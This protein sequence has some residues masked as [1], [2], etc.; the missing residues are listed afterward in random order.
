MPAI[1]LVA[2]DL[3]GTLLRKGGTLSEYSQGVL[4]RTQAGGVQLVLVTGRPVRLVR[5][6]ARDVAP[7][8]VLICGNG[9]VLYDA[10]QDAVLEQFPITAEVMREV[11]VRLRRGLPEVAFAVESGLAIAREAAYVRHSRKL[12]DA[13]TEVADALELCA[14]GA[15]KLIAL[16]PGMPLDEFLAQARGLIAELAHVTHAGA[17]FIEISAQGVTKAWALA[18]YCEQQGIVPDEVLAFGDMPNDLPMLE[19]AGNSVAVANAHPSVLAAARHQTAS[20]EDDGVARFIER[21]LLG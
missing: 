12:G 14:R 16:H 21:E 4:Q 18:R 2:T 5:E 7:E 15:S 20:N 11:I 6:L 1:R 8:S 10:R 13:Q 3:D 17:P 19:W 9:A